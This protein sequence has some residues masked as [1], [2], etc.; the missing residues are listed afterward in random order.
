M[1]KIQ[2]IL[3]KIYYNAK[4]PAGY[5]GI[6]A[7]YN[8]AK[9]H[10]KNITRGQVVKYLQQQ[11]T[12]TKHKSVRYKFPRRKTL[13]KYPNFLWQCDLIDLGNDIA[14]K[15]K[16]FRYIL[17]AIDVLTR[18]VRASPL[19]NKTA[20]AVLNSF[21]KMMKKTKPTKIQTDDGGEFMNR[22]LKTF[23]REK[24]II[25]YSTSSDTKAALAERWNRFFQEKL[26]RYF[27]A[28]NTKY[29]LNILPKLVY[30]YNHKIHSAH[31][32]RPVD[33]N[34]KNY[35]EV[36]N[37]LY[38]DHLEKRKRKTP[39]FRVGDVIRLSKYKNTFK[40]G[41]LSSW[42]NELFKIHSVL[43]TNPYTYKIEDNSGEILK[44]SFYEQELSKVLS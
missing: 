6:N 19:K 29:F 1:T 7:L 32:K 16:G 43:H 18:F 25:I 8:A 23:L 14:Q 33:I 9:K 35:K 3:E 24:N 15:N 13:A 22:I 4:H 34:S 37:K 42:T 20:S 2:K 26:F 5:G 31:G 39:K 44:G 28:K 12:Y 21:K 27:T 38:K 41:Y 11:E 30:A 40:R 36:W 10:Q 17:V